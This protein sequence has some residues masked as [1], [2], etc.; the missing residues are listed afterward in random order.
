LMQDTLLDQIGRIEL[1]AQQSAKLMQDTLLDQIGRIEI[2]A[3]Q[4]AKLMQDAANRL[5]ASVAGQE[6]AATAQTV[7]NELQSHALDAL[8]AAFEERFRGSR[9]EIK[10]RVAVYL[11]KLRDAGIGTREMP[12]LDV[13]CGR[14]EW[15]ELLKEQGLHATGVEINPIFVEHCRRYNLK[16]EQS[17][18]FAYLRTLPD[19]S[20]GAVTG[21]HIIEHLPFE[22]LIKLLDETLRVLN[23]GG[24]AIFETP[25]PE[26][27]SVGSNTFYL[28]PT[29]RNPLPSAM[30]GFMLQARG[31]CRVEILKLHPS[32]EANAP[33][34]HELTSRFNEL[35][36]GPQDY[37]VIGIRP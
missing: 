1:S 6:R 9:Q 16:V 15:L 29:H 5:S 18:L 2:S 35:F 3:Q 25:N 22:M 10:Q 19:E 17:D 20:L 27:V 11:P 21:F 7:A 31:F 14:G 23:P 13:A 33:D 32:R 28:D 34:D 26:N 12:I 30:M 4:S 36:Y 8:Y 24:I 37:A